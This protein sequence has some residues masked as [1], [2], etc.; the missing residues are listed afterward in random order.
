MKLQN[1]I[2]NETADLTDK[3]SL[4]KNLKIDAAIFKSVL[5]NI[6]DSSVG[7]RLIIKY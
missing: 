7:N 5:E 3:L 4:D 6:A 1:L 2:T